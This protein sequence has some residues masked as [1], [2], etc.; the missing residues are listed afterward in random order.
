MH[1]FTVYNLRSHACTNYW[2]NECE[3]DLQA[4]TFTS[5]IIYHLQTYFVPN[6]KI[7]IYSDGCGYQN[8]NAVLSNALLCFAV[9]NNVI[10]EQKYLEK[11]HTQMECDAVHSMIDRK[12]K[13]RSIYLPYQFHE[14]TMQAREKPF[15]LNSKYLTHDFFLDYN[16]NFK[17]KS[18]RPGRKAHDATVVD[19]RALKYHTDGK[20]Y[21]K[22]NY[23]EQYTEVPTRTDG[24]FKFK[25]TVHKLFKSQIKI[26]I[27]KY[28][29]LQE[30]KS[31]LPQDTHSFYNLPRE[32]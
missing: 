5:C 13:N 12:I 14:I 21:F 22:V 10:V 24:N 11:G 1:N 17:Y 2:W 27:S 4:S 28:K 6:R 16:K 15:S 18:I 26:K 19:I 31:L 32:Q 25:N 8:R 23:N 29:H 20:I 9:Q 30:L 3:A 7:I